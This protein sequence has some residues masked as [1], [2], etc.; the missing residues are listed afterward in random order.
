MPAFSDTYVGATKKDEKGAPVAHGHGCI[1]YSAT[2][3]A[4]GPT[5]LCG[6]FKGGKPS[7]EMKSIETGITYLVTYKDGVVIEEPQPVNQCLFPKVLIKVKNGIYYGRTKNNIGAP[8]GIPEGDGETYHKD[9]S[10]HEGRYVGGKE[11]GY[12]VKVYPNGDR[13][14]GYFEND[15]PHDHGTMVYA[16]GST[17]SGHWKHGQRHGKCHVTLQDGTFCVGTYDQDEPSGSFTVVNEDRPLESYDGEVKD[18]IPHGEGEARY[19]NGR[20][21]Y[22][23]GTFQNGMRHGEGTALDRDGKFWAGVWVKDTLTNASKR[24]RP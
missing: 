20:Y 10:Y 3:G 4:F 16:D 24:P 6:S 7:G 1:V 8:H 5:I 11:H 13:F 22:Y 14:K 2:E 18:F 17:C 21:I 15:K 9:G 12:G 23:K 19:K